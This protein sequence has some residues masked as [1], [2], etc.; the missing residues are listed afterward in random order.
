MIATI[1]SPVISDFRYTKPRTFTRAFLNQSINVYVSFAEYV[2][3]V[4]LSHYIKYNATQ[5]E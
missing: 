2:A 5:A 4:R 3:L 1:I